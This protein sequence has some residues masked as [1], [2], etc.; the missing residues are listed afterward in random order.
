MACGNG[1]AVETKGAGMALNLTTLFTRIGALIDFGDKVE[2]HRALL[3]V[4]V[5]DVL[6]EYNNDRE[7]GISLESGLPGFVSSAGSPLSTLGSIISNTIIEMVHADDPLPSKD[8]DSA[9]IRLRDQMINSS[10]SLDGTTV[11]AST[12]AAKVDGTSNVGNGQVVV[13]LVDARGNT[14]QYVRAE[15][16]VLECTNDAQE[17]GTAGRETFSL[18]GELSTTN[19]D[20][21]WPDGSGLSGSITLADPSNDASA[22]IGQNRLTNSDFED[23][24]ANA[25]DSWTI[26][27]GAAGGT[28]TKT[29]TQ[30]RGTNALEFA[31]NG[32]ELTEI[33]FALTGAVVVKPNKKYVIGFWVRDD[34]TGPAAGVLS[35]SLQSTG[36][37]IYNSA[38]S[39]TTAS[40]TV[41]LTSVGS[42]YAFQSIAFETPTLLPTGAKVVIE[43]TTALTNGRSVF[44]DGC[45]MAE[46]AQFGGAGGPFVIMTPGATNF[47]REDRFVTTITNNNEGEFV[48]GLDRYLSLYE[49]GLY[50]P[51]LTDGNETISDALVA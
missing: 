33:S 41:D 20:E 50:L 31:G 44:I 48:R 2:T 29:T 26:D 4:E 40:K 30:H 14:T 35:V 51:T 7:L 28:V 37:T 36:G 10:D 46:M 45:F 5:D 47:I 42:T 18:K 39:L 43:L 22:A 24:T 25:P 17:S 19:L 27:T 1:G 6:D 13:S 16:I 11:S 23:F 21:K 34:G 38:T 9:L 3:V 12:A 15:S 49:K 8:I 32:S